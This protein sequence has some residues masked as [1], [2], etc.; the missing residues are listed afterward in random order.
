M[1]RT[2]NIRKLLILLVATGCLATS[3]WAKVT[4]ITETSQGVSGASRLVKALSS[5]VSGFL[6]FRAPAT[7]ANGEDGNCLG[8][9]TGYECKERNGVFNKLCTDIDGVEWGTCKC[10]D[11]FYSLKEWCVKS[12]PSQ[13]NECMM[14]VKPDER[15]E[16]CTAE[17]NNDGVF[18]TKY[19]TYA[20]MCKQTFST[21]FG[22]DYYYYNE[23]EECDP[24]D[25][26]TPVPCALEIENEKGLP[27]WI[28]SKVCMNPK[29][30]RIRDKK[31]DGYPERSLKNPDGYYWKCSLP[32]EQAERRFD[33][34]CYKENNETIKDEELDDF[35]PQA[36]DSETPTVKCSRSGL[37]PFCENVPREGL[38]RIIGRPAK[39]FWLEGITNEMIDKL[40]AFGGDFKYCS[41]DVDPLGIQNIIYKGKDKSE[42]A[43]IGLKTSTEFFR[44]KEG[45][46]THINQTCSGYEFQLSCKLDDDSES[47]SICLSQT[48]PDL[49]ACRFGKRKYAYLTK[50]EALAAEPDSDGVAQ[51]WVLCMNSGYCT[52][53]QPYPSCDNGLAYVLYD[54]SSGCTDGAKEWCM[55]N[56]ELE[57]VCRY[58]DKCD[59][60][61]MTLAEWC[62]KEHPA[63][64]DCTSNYVGNSNNKM[65]CLL[66]DEPKF[67]EFGSKCAQEPDNDKIQKVSTDSCKPNPSDTPVY[68]KCYI[69]TEQDGVLKTDEYYECSC[70]ASYVSS[71]E[72]QNFAPGGTKCA[73][74]G[75]VKHQGCYYI[76]GTVYAPSYAS[77]ENTCPLVGGIYE[78]TWRGDMCADPLDDSIKYVCGCPDFFVTKQEYC[79]KTYPKQADRDKCLQDYSGY[80]DVCRQELAP[81]GTVLEKYTSYAN[82]CP[83]GRDLYYS[84][85]ECE[86]FGGI[87]ERSCLL[88]DGTERVLC[89]CDTSWKLESECEALGLEGAGETCS[90][91]GAAEDKVKYSKCVYPCNKVMTKTYV[92]DQGRAYKYVDSSKAVPTKIMCQNLL[93]NG[94]SFGANSVMGSSVECSQNHELRYPCFCSVDME[95]CDPDENKYPKN[96]ALTCTY[97]GVTFYGAADGLPC[98]YIL[99]PKTGPNSAVVP[100]STDTGVFGKAVVKTCLNDASGMKHVTCDASVYKYACNYP[101][102]NDETLSDFCR[103]EDDASKNMS[104]SSPKHYRRQE[105]CNVRLEFASCGK[106]LIDDVKG[107]ILGVANSAAECQSKY[108]TGAQAQLCEYGEAQ[109][110]KRAF[111]CYYVGEYAYHTGNCG[112]RHDLT[113]PWVMINGVKHWNECTCA[114]SYKYHKYNCGG[115]FSGKPCAQKVYDAAGVK[116]YEDA[117]L[118]SSVSQVDLYPYCTCTPEFNQV[119]DEDGSGRYKGVGTPCNG[120]YKSCECVPDEIPLNWADNYYGCPNG[121]RPTGVWKNNGCGKKYYQCYS[122]ECTWEYTEQCPSPLIGVG[123]PCQ[124]NQGNVGGYKSCRCPAEYTKVCGKDE[125]GVGEPCSLKGVLYYKSCQPQ[126][127]CLSNQSETCTGNLQ[128]GVNPCLRDEI[129]Y[130]EKCICA[131]GY[132][133]VCG[134]GEVG[135]GKF[136]EINGVRYYKECEKPQKEECTA[137]HVT[138][139]DAN[140]ES[141]SPCYTTDENGRSVVKYLCRCP[142]N[143]FTCSGEGEAPATDAETCT[144]KASDG[145]V[146]TTYNKCAKAEGTTCTEWQSKNYKYCA[147]SEIGSG[148]DCYDEEGKVKYAEC[149]ETKS[150][151]ANG[152]KYTCQEH[153]AEWLGETCVDAF[154]NK[155]YRE[156]PCPENYV[157]CPGSNTTKGQRCV[158]VHENGTV[159]APVYESCACDTSK[160]KYTCEGDENNLGVEP[161]VNGKYCALFKDVT[162]KNGIVTTIETRY[163]QT[164]SC[165]DKY[166]YTCSGQGQYVQEEDR[167]DYCEVQG[168]R[169]YQNCACTSSYIYTAEDCADV[170]KFGNGAFADI[171]AGACEVKGTFGKWSNVTLYKTCSCRA[172][173]KKCSNREVKEGLSDF[174]RR[175]DGTVYAP[176]CTGQEACPT[177]YKETPGGDCVLCTI[178]NCDYCLTSNVCAACLTGY[179]L[180]DGKCQKPTEQCLVPHC[181]TCLDP[182]TCSVCK[183]E[184]TVEAGDADPC[185]NRAPKELIQR[186]QK[187]ILVEG[188][189]V[190]QCYVCGCDE[191]SPDNG[192]ICLKCQEGFNLQ[193]VGTPPITQTLCIAPPAEAECQSYPE[194]ACYDDNK[195]LCKNCEC[196]ECKT[197]KGRIQYKK[198][199]GSCKNGYVRSAIKND[200]GTIN[201]D[202]KTCVK[203]GDGCKYCDDKPQCIQCENRSHTI[204][205]IDCIAPD[206]CAGYEKDDCYDKTNSTCEHCKCDECDG[207]YKEWNGKTCKSGYKLNIA[208]K[209]INGKDIA[210]NMTCVSCNIQ[211]CAGCA[212]NDVCAKCGIINSQ[213]YVLTPSGRYCVM[214]ITG[215]EVYRDQQASFCEKCEGGYTLNS[216]SCTKDE[217]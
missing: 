39:G 26:L 1:F 89:H 208:G 69:Q 207:K 190:A 73:W 67:L 14:Y 101:Y 186:N 82:F 42:C 65:T 191:C 8:E 46:R 12:Y 45:P 115:I 143:Y 130:Y 48:K 195:K 149:R 116:V 200:D 94:A 194:T 169:Y 107:T 68:T 126:N 66:E 98:T 132:D 142:S 20:K 160:F 19:K 109:R 102:E 23:N 136:C 185:G 114:P 28:H 144:Q 43:A 55:H 163:Y 75:D 179:E 128:L 13:E 159:D 193:R 216:G 117:A 63:D 2:G 147:A 84:K 104:A 176:T 25:K 64:P 181:R 52:A 129:T 131:Q 210:E 83:S 31:D 47:S 151:E 177:G 187:F 165:A 88:R 173:Y 206:K 85:S 50:E 106:T 212:M 209:D 6:G 154:G 60:R 111:N 38:N 44:K 133:K 214:P 58:E 95:T 74:D 153:K 11:A 189:C 138:A 91:E 166:K 10:S 202:G 70:P 121:K 140:Q 30:C 119:C 3:A 17:K 124:D 37:S 203:C 29:K 125:V 137:G 141:Y 158:A 80:G 78:T 215:C 127:S 135:L 81:D 100:A 161:P 62:A 18:I 118:P 156:C 196:E 5:S 71:C 217:G 27:I 211:N 134:E 148:G 178:Q 87:Y 77:T 201:P 16:K 41:K 36:W 86:A 205:G 22:Q 49:P 93:G 21:D 188:K 15:S 199:D 182:T 139:C 172:D 99:C 175:P 184:E 146:K 53:W 171:S 162:D 170:D 72:T 90:L 168:V 7:Y 164:C 213:Q 32:G 76:C 103:Y 96:D 155:L 120:K 108:G 157:S 204:S 54:E 180:V 110:Y 61:L 92:A 152:F 24:D 122:N 97:N 34:T 56:G 150:C 33:R 197:S 4:P 105:D 167:D 174:C 123:E 145:T 35:F 198:W 112:V 40:H 57:G 9:S 183:T 79:K 59:T 192:Y 51:C 113:G